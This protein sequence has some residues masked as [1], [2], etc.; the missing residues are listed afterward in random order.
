M[1]QAFVKAFARRNRSGRDQSDQPATTEPTTSAPVTKV[2]DEPGSLKVDL[3]VAGTAEVWVDPI[4][5]Q[6]ARAD[7][8]Q[9]GL[10][11]P[12]VESP[13]GE[14]P[15][16]ESPHGEPQTEAENVSDLTGIQ[17]AIDTLQHIHTAYATAFA[18]P[19]A[20]AAGPATTKEPEASPEDAAVPEPAPEVV[21]PEPM[22]S[23]ETTVAM[24]STVVAETLRCARSRNR[25]ARAEYRCARGKHRC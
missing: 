1:D 8:A 24:D 7:Y 19:S 21:K 3:S 17:Q 10:P 18:D 23:G 13:H 20:A 11:K 4:E 2:T 22:R 16:G 9:F 6:I 12:H 14:P 15:H 5:D 25:C